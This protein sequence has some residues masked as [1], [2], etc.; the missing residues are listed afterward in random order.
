MKRD[1]QQIRQLKRP[2]SLNK[3]RLSYLPCPEHLGS[4]RPKLI[5]YLQKFYSFWLPFAGKVDCP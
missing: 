3:V 4:F 2:C 1:F 5:V